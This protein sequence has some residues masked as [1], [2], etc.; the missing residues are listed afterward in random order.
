MPKGVVNIIFRAIAYFCIQ[1]HFTQQQTLKDF[2]Q[3]FPDFEFP[4][5]TI[6]NWYSTILTYDDIIPPSYHH[7][8]Y[9][10]LNVA[11]LIY[12]Y[13]KRHHNISARDISRRTGIP[14]STV[15]HYLYDVLHLR[16]R[17][18]Q[19][20]PYELDRSLRET[21][22]LFAKVQ[23]AILKEAKKV[24]YE[25]LITLD[26]S[27]FFHSYPAR[28][29]YQEATAPRQR[30][31]RRNQNNKKIMLV[32]FIGGFGY[33][34]HYVLP[35]KT[36]LDSEGLVKNCIARAY[37]K[38]IAIFKT[39]SNQRQAEIHAATE[40]GMEAAKAV[41][42]EEGL[43]KKKPLER[44]KE[45][46]KNE[47]LFLNLSQEKRSCTQSSQSMLVAFIIFLSLLFRYSR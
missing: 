41:I 29:S 19:M 40:A 14:L 15:F 17:T 18:A 45:L 37:Q 27:W 33:I 20:I 30:L 43:V 38:W 10:N 9:N 31:V 5:Q 22:K 12:S 23:L 39:K 1:R 47:E 35:E 7:G 32:P 25:N 4:H 2:C 46:S 8:R 44:D 34:D 13:V 42:E 36:T 21:R 3:V 24:D 28:W 16:R 6:S 26:E 11:I